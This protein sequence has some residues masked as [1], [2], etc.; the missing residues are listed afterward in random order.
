MNIHDRSEI[1]LSSYQIEATR[2]NKLEYYRLQ[3]HVNTLNVDLENYLA[4]SHRQKQ[5][6][7]Y[8][9]N[10]VVRF[11]KPKPAFQRWKQAHAQEIAD[12][13]ADEIIREHH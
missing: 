7:R 1:V 10:N 9:Y 12:D 8:H 5:C 2:L 3:R 11:V 6:L 13:E 4:R